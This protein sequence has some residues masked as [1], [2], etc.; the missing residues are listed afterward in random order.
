[1]SLLHPYVLGGALIAAVLL[2]GGGYVKGR[3]DGRSLERTVALQNSI[4]LI[5]E[6]NETNVEIGRMD[7]AALCRELGGVWVQPDNICK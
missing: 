2:C 7:D 4:N 3:I 6:R 1:M 5:Q